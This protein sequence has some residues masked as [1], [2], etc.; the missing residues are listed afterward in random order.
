MFLLAIVHVSRI[1]READNE[2][3]SRSPVSFTSYCWKPLI[4]ET[5]E[6]RSNKQTCSK[7]WS[8][9]RDFLSVVDV[10]VDL[11]AIERVGLSIDRRACRCVQTGEVESFFGR[12]GEEEGERISSYL[13]T[14]FAACLRK[15]EFRISKGICGGE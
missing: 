12:G 1:A 15:A 11:L 9:V 5:R 14:M 7:V 2:A 3:A 8:N 4:P 10:V 13:G 6:P